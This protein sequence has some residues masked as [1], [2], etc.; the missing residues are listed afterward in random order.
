[1]QLTTGSLFQL[2]QP[3]QCTT[4]TQDS[5]GGGGAPNIYWGKS[6]YSKHLIGKLLWPFT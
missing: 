6:L 5:F 3:L 2:A 4:I 1:M